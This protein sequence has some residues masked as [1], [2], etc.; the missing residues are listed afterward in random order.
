[1]PK[2]RTKENDFNTRQIQLAELRWLNVTG[3][4]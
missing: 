4:T 2:Y 1:M 3:I